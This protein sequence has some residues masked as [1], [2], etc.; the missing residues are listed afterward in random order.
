VRREYSDADK[1]T[2][3]AALDANGGNVYRT[4]KALSIPQST[5]E[6]WAKS[7]GT[8]AAI[9]NLR[10]HKK[11]ALAE[12]L[13]EI[14]EKLAEAIPGKV[15]DATLQQ[16]AT[17]LGIVVDKMQ[18]LRGQP[19]N[20]TDDASLTDTERANRVAALLDLARTRRDGQALD[21]PQTSG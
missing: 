20:I 19:T 9:P 8:N 18:L 13:E 16:T 5:L 3:L 15:G 14:A 4:A 1:A 17:S 10:E 12:Q 7:R 2:A 6:G 11:K 21:A